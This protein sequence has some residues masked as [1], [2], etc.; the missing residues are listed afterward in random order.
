MKSHVR[1]MHEVDEKN[2]S[3]KVSTRRQGARAADNHQRAQQLQ[4][5]YPAERDVPFAEDEVAMLV[6][7][8]VATRRKGA[9]L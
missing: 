4:Q 3:K 9:P 5:Q 1:I 8:P 7:A 2:R 6:V